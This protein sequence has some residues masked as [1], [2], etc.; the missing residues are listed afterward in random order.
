[1]HRARRQA[2]RTFLCGLL[3]GVAASAAASGPAAPLVPPVATFEEQ[4]A[5]LVNQE[6]ADCTLAACPLSPLKLV[7]VLGAL[8]DEHS[9]SMAGEE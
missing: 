2:T 4:V 3:A 6:R 1:M 8:A 7:S 5:E 9:G